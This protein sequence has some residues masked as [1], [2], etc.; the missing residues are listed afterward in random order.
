MTVGVT[1]AVGLEVQVDLG[2]REGVGLAV[3]VDVAVGGHIG[4]GLAV[5]V[6]VGVGENVGI[7]A[8]STGT[9]GDRNKNGAAMIKTTSKP[10]MTKK[11]GFFSKT[12]FLS[13]A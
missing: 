7:S 3:R 10:T 2:V 8:T 13:R 6:A 1:L 4:L 5:T 12:R 9:S 11:P